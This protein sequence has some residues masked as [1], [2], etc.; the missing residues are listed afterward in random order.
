MDGAMSRSARINSFSL[1]QRTFTLPSYVLS[2]T[3]IM[4]LTLSICLVMQVLGIP[5][6]LIDLFT[7]DTSAESS[8]SE[9][10]SIPTE[11]SQVRRP[12]NPFFIEETPL[13]YHLLL[14]DLILRPPQ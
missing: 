11:P 7:T 5:V 3:C 10:F 2:Q 9:G 1:V 6:G 8:L 4:I 13:F 12:T 14:S